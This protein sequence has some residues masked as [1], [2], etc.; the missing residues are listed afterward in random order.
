[1]ERIMKIESQ[2]KNKLGLNKF[3]LN[4]IFGGIL[5]A[6]AIVGA[7]TLTYI[8]PADINNNLGESFDNELF[9]TLETGMGQLAGEVERLLTEKKQDTLERATQNFI[10]EKT[11]FTNGLVAQLMPMAESFDVEGIAN[12]IDHQIKAVSSFVGAKVRTEK[13]GAWI[14]LGD[15]KY[16]G[17]RTFTGKGDSE[18]AFVELQVMIATDKFQETLRLEDESFTNLLSHIKESTENTV[19]ST[20]EKTN[21]IKYALAS[22]ARWV[23]GITVAI[24]MAIFTGLVLF[25]L[26]KIVIKPLGAAGQQ[27]R[28]IA[29]G[30]LTV[31]IQVNGEDEVN[32]LLAAMKDMTEKMHANIS[33]VSASTAEMANAA[34]QMSAITDETNQGILKQQSEID[35]V[36]TAINQMTATVQE[37][38]RNAT[39]AAHAT[40]EADTETKNGQQVVSDTI[41]SIDKL[42]N[43]VQ[44]A[45]KVIHKLESDSESITKV[46]DVIKGIAEQTNLLALNAAIEA[47]RAGEQGR[48]FAVVADEVRTLAARTQDSTKEI[49][50]MIEQLQTGAR[51]AVQVMEASSSQAQATVDQAAGAGTALAAITN[52]I[53]SINEMN[54]HIATA[55]EEQTQTT[56]DIN[57]NIV[58]IIQVVAETS[59]GSQRTAGAGESL[60]KLAGDLQGLVAQF[61]I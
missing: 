51:Q 10:D 14:E 6:L 58:N 47:A 48:G 12:A 61:K 49:E 40:Q 44:S 26:N 22:S 13:D 50:S 9:P 25:L 41:N 17:A 27:L 54:T 3:S 36:A 19:K 4:A 30:D 5:L 15:I 55:A 20:H 33:T 8:L 35:Q 21:E 38:T 39:D 16:A 56:E 23:I 7:G 31:A 53:T 37:V 46:L 11:T 45:T 59:K 24:F 2:T 28:E 32:Q 60:S 57:R 34:D 43:E 18:Y 52:A 1:M 42:A 29:D